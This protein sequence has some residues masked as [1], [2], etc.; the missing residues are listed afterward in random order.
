MQR[1]GSWHGEAVTWVRLQERAAR[2]AKS[3]P[4]SV[5]GLMQS[6]SKF[7]TQ[8]STTPGFK[9]TDLHFPTSNVYQTNYLAPSGGPLL[10]SPAKKEAGKKDAA[11]VA[12]AAPPP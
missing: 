10:S 5:E 7:S 12:G 3:N 6:K 1:K 11:R 8:Y 9:K 4:Y 2:L